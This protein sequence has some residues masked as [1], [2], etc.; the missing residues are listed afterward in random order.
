[1]HG[2]LGC[3][4]VAEEERLDL[5]G[6]RIMNAAFSTEGDLWGLMSVDLVAPSFDC[7]AKADEA[8]QLRHGS[9]KAAAS[10]EAVKVSV[11]A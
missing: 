11:K 4:S 5:G 1:M 3:R 7:T 6:S 8:E 2:G 10:R 9:R